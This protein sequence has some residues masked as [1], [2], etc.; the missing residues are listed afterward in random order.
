MI[1]QLVDQLHDP[2]RSTH[3]PD[4]TTG[5]EGSLLAASTLRHATRDVC[6]C[7]LGAAGFGYQTAVT[8]SA[9]GRPR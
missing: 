6:F 5:S 3:D 8:A 7:G 4:P 1:L 2:D 9:S